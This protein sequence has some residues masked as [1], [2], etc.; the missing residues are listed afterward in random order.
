MHVYWHAW[1]YTLYRLQ[2][3]T[4]H[5]VYWIKKIFYA[6]VCIFDTWKLNIQ[7]LATA[8]INQFSQSISA[9]RAFYKRI[10]IT[11]CLSREC[12]YVGSDDSFKCGNRICKLK[13]NSSEIES[14]KG[15]LQTSMNQRLLHWSNRL[16]FRLYWVKN[17]WKPCAIPRIVVA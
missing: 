1:V 10:Y 15:Q 9:R 17:E 7:L 8:A 16:L 11:L 4:S 13:I 2:Q 3:L 5:P 12:S 6:A 14:G